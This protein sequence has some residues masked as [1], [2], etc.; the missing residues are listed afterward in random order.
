MMNWL[1]ILTL[2]A[3]IGCGGV[4][5]VFFAISTF[6]MK[7]LRRLPPREAIAAMQAI[8]VA[9]IN[10]LFL[11]M[12]LG[13]GL[14]CAAAIV[15]ALVRFSAPGTTWVIV[16]GALYLVGTLGVTM[17][18]NVPLNNALAAV[19]PDDAEAPGRWADYA[20]RWTAWNHLRTVAALAALAA[21]IVALRR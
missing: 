10:P 5:G 18:F 14:T 6:V 17:A 20:R 15:R 3:A 4:G 19:A 1:T 13:T 9:V 2:V 12:F 21:F 16:G 8:N 11:G 7:A